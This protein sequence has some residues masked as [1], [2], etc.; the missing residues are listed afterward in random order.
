MIH[1][2]LRNDLRLVY[3]HALP[4]DER[5]WDGLVNLFPIPAYAPRLYSFGTS[6]EIWARG[7]LDVVGG[8]ERLIVVGNSIG[9]SCALEMAR[10]APERI[11]TLVL[12][13]TK[14]GHRPEPEFRDR[15]IAALERDPPAVVRRWVDELLAPECPIEVRERVHAIA[16]SQ[17]IDDLVR[18][19]RVFHTR[20]DATDVVASWNRPIV[21]VRGEFDRMH[22]AFSEF[23]KPQTLAK[24][25][26]KSDGMAHIQMRTVRNCGH[27]ANLEQPHIFRQLLDDVLQFATSPVA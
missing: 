18:G 15:F 5:Q 1:T 8:R 13:G 23:R 6:L 14:A 4:L 26:Q 11:A 7:V 3:L 25:S 22:S 27:Y 10:L 21:W 9:G 2:A 16:Q 17:P 12:V 20:P 24:S 19:V